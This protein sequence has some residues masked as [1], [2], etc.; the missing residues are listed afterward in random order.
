MRISNIF[1]Y[2]RAIIKIEVEGFFIERFI[3]LCKIN[4]IKIWD[5]VYVNS[6]M[7]TFLTTPK[8]YK[9]IQIYLKKTKCKSKIV[10]RKG[11]YFE[12]FRYRKRRNIIILT[13]IALIIW[14]VGSTFI[15]RINISGNKRIKDEKIIAILNEANVGFGKNKL[16]IS[17]GKTVDYIRK[18]IYDIAWVGLEYSGTTLNV[19]VVEK[20]IENTD[21][22]PNIMGNILSTK[23]G[24]I[25]K[26]IAK[27]GTA[28]YKTGSY[29]GKGMV[30]I[31]GSIKSEL[32]EEKKVHASGILKAVIDYKFEK[33][34]KYEENVKEYA[35][36]KRY[37]IGI[38]INNKKSEL[39]YL[40]KE[41][42]YDISSKVKDL[43]I[44]GVKISF[45]FNV[46]KEYNV[47]KNKYSL[48]ELLNKGKNDSGEYIKKLL[49]NENK[50]LKEDV[51]TINTKDRNKVYCVL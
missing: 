23:S 22:D 27:N 48:K 10:K 40:I 41:N 30:A 11:V 17:K 34:Y 36:K 49:V 33:E 50:L 2:F 31:E 26:I 45:I 43:S 19:K 20:V 24:I 51:S 16:F 9:K 3:N 15:W 4:N 32:V 38:G 37:G 28:L 44:F 39:K 25:T 35:D 18:N 14:I 8:E 1:T 5:I 47:V 46:Y 6:G 21:D 7:I 42:K 13:G 12:L 29:I